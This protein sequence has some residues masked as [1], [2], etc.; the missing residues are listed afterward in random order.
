MFTRREAL[1]TTAQLG[2][3][4]DLLSL[5]LSDPHERFQGDWYRHYKALFAEKL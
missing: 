5:V 3:A 4:M 1:Q 2:A